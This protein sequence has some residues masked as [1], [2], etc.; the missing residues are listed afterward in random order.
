[1]LALLL[2]GSACTE[3]SSTRAEG[4]QATVSA[5]G[6]AS[7][8]AT[9]TTSPSVSPSE[10]EVVTPITG[11]NPFEE[12]DNIVSIAMKDPATLDPMLIGD[13]GSTLVA[14]QLYD[15]LTRWDTNKNQVVPAVAQSWK[16]QAKGAKYTFELR[17]GLT[18]HDGSAV[19]ADSFVFAFD[20]IAKRKSASELAYLLRRV[21]G[22]D[23]VNKVGRTDHLEG[24]KAPD[25]RTLVIE[26][27]EPDQDFPAVLTH[28]GLVP[29]SRDAVA[30]ADEFLRNP[31]GNG[32][33]Q[34]AQPWDVGGEIFLEAFNGAPQKPQVD[35]LRL[36]PYP[37]A[38]ASWLDFIGGQ[39][40]ISETPAGQ[41][42]DAG[43][44][45][46]KEGFKPLMNG[47]S[48]GL[49]L[50]S[51]N[52]QNPTLRRAIN[53]AIGRATIAEVVYNGIMELP[54]GIVPPG[55]PGFQKD[56][57]KEQC[58][59]DP[60]AA[61]RLANRVPARARNVTLEFPDE[62]PHPEV[63]RLIR[64]ALGRVG[65]EV[66]LAPLKFKDFFDLLQADEHS[67]YRLTWIAEYH[68][69][70]AYLGALFESDSPNN[71]SGFS[72]KK[73]DSL[74]EK[75][76]AEPKPKK[77]LKLYAKVEVEILKSSPIVPIG[78][79]TVHWSAQDGVEGLNVDSTGGFDAVALTKS[80]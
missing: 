29:L 8:E 72:S 75:A 17:P 23:E 13:A 79:F 54:R 71:H 15:G 2:V 56:L 44:Q 34:M 31:V 45:F 9:S 70:D 38:A 1:M 64:R 14:R 62:A 76:R 12:T 55:V 27:T 73:V 69:P 60:K 36:I 65:I 32:P 16:V 49:N 77:R 50:K 51:K 18:F 21:V 74:L 42:E 46:G 35:G 80:G 53:M 10:S 24:L 30:N 7:P 37:E 25:D 11:K 39:L 19:T 78:Y 41:I 52:L 58:S 20:R 59:F 28:P 6:S 22:F 33:F 47:Y 26:L 40:D 43:A 57:C 48:F 67:M 3:S 68:S 61:R 5:P 66:T 63:A 4:P